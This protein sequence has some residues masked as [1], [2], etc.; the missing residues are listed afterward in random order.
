MKMYKKKLV[1]GTKFGDETE[2]Y[3]MRKNIYDV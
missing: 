3:V 2:K 1:I